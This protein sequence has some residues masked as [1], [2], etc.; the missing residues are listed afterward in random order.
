MR[1]G[2]LE[3]GVVTEARDPREAVWAD[4]SRLFA[5]QKRG[6]P[7]E[8]VDVDRDRLTVL[9]LRSNPFASRSA[10]HNVDL[11]PFADSENG[12]QSWMSLEAA[13]EKYWASSPAD[14]QWK[15]MG[16]HFALWPRSE[17]RIAGVLFT[18]PLFSRR[19][20]PIVLTSEF[21]EVVIPIHRSCTRLHILGQVSFPLGFPLIGRAG[22]SVA[23]Y[24]LQYVS[25][26]TQ[27]LPVRHGIEVAQANCIDGAT[28]IAPTAT[29]AQSAVKYVRDAAREQYQALLWSISAQPEEIASL[30][31]QLHPSQ[32]AIAIFAITLEHDTS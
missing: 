26:K 15:R 29:A 10:F 3:S 1:D 6:G 7:Q 30:Q 22:Q 32:P 5:G 16:S 9:P 18:C 17:L 12:R 2:V 14:D 13:L 31:C 28:R 25:G 19:V 8:H 23:L 11:Q 21:P 20:R 24:S 27:R 4:L